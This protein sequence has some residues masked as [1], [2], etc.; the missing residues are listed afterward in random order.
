MAAAA[1][2]GIAMQPVQHD[3]EVVH[4]RRRIEQLEVRHALLVR[5]YT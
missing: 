2:P 4:L 5:A 1:N 3:G